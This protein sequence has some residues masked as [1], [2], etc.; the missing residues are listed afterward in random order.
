MSR[1]D[2]TKQFVKVANLE[3]VTD[4]DGREDGLNT[5]SLQAEEGIRDCLLTRGLGDVYKRQL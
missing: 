4:N 2:N 1:T 3:R 5:F